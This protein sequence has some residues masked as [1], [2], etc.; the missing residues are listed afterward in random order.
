MPNNIV[1][2]EINP[3]L[4]PT[5]PEVQDNLNHL[6]S[7]LNAIRDAYGK[8]LYITSGL[9][10]EEDQ[11]RINPKAPKSKHLTGQ[12]AD[13]SDIDGKFWEWCQNNMDLMINLNVYF[14]DTR[15]T[16]GWVHCQVVAPK[17]G[18]RVFIP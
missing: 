12:A 14:E 13:I 5:T 3:H 17:S 9:R 6:I 2:K 11:K 10:S 1:L 15:Y 7:V 16:K 4:Y 18:K 8:P